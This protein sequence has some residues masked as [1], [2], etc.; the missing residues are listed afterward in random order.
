MQNKTYATDLTDERWKVIEPLLP[1]RQ[2][3]GRPPTERRRI[4][5]GLFYLVRA[6][7]AWRLLPKEFGPWEVHR[8]CGERNPKDWCPRRWESQEFGLSHAI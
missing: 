3:C 1:Q 6:G 4:L 7:C 5:N 8:N 2:P